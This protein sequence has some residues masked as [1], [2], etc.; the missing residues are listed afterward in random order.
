LRGERELGPQQVDPSA[1][2]LVER[3][4][5]RCGQE[6]L[7]VAERARLQA[8]LRRG[9][10]AIGVPPA[11]PRQRDGAPEERRRGGEAAARL[12]PHGGAF[13]LDGHPLVRPGRGRREMPGAAVG[14]AAGF[15]HLRQGAMDVAPR[16]RRRGPVRGGP[17]QR[18]AEPH[19][20]ADHQQPPGLRGL[21]GRRR[22]PEPVGRAPEQHGIADWL[23]R[24]DEQ[25]TPRLIRQRLE[26]SDEALLDPSAQRRLARHGEAAR[27]LGRSQPA[28]QFEQRQ[29]IAARLGDEA[30][31]HLRVHGVANRSAQQRARV[32]VAQALHVELG[33]VPQLLDRLAGGE[34]DGDRVGHQ[35]AGDERQ[36]HRRSTVEPLRIV[37]HAQ[38]RALLGH[39]GEQAQ[40]RQRHEEPIRGRAVAEAEHRLE[41]PALR[42]RERREPVEHRAAQLMQAGERQLH[43]GLHAG[44]P[45]DGQ[46]RC[47]G[48]EVLQQ[49]GLPDPGLAPEDQGTAVALT[50]VADQGIEHDALVRA[51]EQAEH[52]TKPSMSER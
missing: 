22:D 9:Q 5:L 15:R 48:D 12:R 16:L 46:V 45:L 34:H 37:D 47:R 27:Q 13:E 25:Q 8:G 28:G 17:R 1:L 4:G 18:M 36:R 49:G 39:L 21:G 52:G 19:P 31:A 23:R 42:G 38:Q 35:A 6:L 43:L 32:I 44:D 20:L 40:H 10:R 41:R 14:I 26:L 7:G 33:E 50:H 29:G 11:I 2:E 24:G 51:P 3:C 30:V